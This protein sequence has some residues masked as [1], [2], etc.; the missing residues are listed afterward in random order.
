M[1][2]APATTTRRRPT[3]TATT[4]THKSTTRERGIA[5]FDDA[6]RK[7]WVNGFR[8][9]KTQRRKRAAHDAETRARQARVR[10]RATRRAAERAAL[11]IAEDEGEDGETATRSGADATETTYASGASVVVAHGLADADA[12]DE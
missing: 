12:E 2:R 9:R 8:K 10:E 4:P 7:D 6:T 11:G 5:T 1:P 3:T